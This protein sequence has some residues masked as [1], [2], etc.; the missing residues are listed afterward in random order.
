NLSVCLEPQHNGLQLDVFSDAS[1][2]GKFSQSTHGFLAQLNGCSVSWCAKRLVKVASSRCHAKFMALG[3]AARHGR[4]MK[5]LL[6]NMLGSS[7]PLQLFCDNTSTIW[8]ATDS[9]SN[10]R[11][12]NSDREFFI[13]NQI[14]RD[15]TATLEWVPTTEKR[16]NTLTKALGSVSHKHMTGLILFGTGK[17]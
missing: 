1:W 3:I 9:S 16:E 15:G 14:L 4:W 13:T 7:T 2:G 17:G 11:T 5:S 12:K 8:I 10:K 6:D